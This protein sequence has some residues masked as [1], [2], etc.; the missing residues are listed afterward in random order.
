MAAPQQQQQERSGRE[1]E[2]E[3]NRGETTTGNNGKQS[4]T[5]T[6]CHNPLKA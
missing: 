6:W 2:R 1:R 5:L 4:A 3:R